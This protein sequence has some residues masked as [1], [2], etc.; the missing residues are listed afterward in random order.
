MQGGISEER[1]LSRSAVDKVAP[2]SYSGVIWQKR[3]SENGFGKGWRCFYHLVVPCFFGAMWLNDVSLSPISGRRDATFVA[4][5][6]KSQRRSIT[7]IEGRRS[8]E[9][10]EN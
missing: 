5:E 4:Q 3:I 6:K 7:S 2:E 10:D 8:P 9:V 1:R